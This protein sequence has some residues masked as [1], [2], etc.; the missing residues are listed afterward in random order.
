MFQKYFHHYDY[1]MCH[2]LVSIFNE[3]YTTN[4]SNYHLTNSTLIEQFQKDMV[5]DKE[6]IEK[7]IR[8]EF[9]EMGLMITEGSDEAMF[10][11]YWSTGGDGFE[12]VEPDRDPVE[13]VEIAAKK[14]ETEV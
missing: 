6:Q 14:L 1:K 4:V 7:L 8:D 12:W 5:L 13:F 9:R 3:I 10:K 11:E 2:K